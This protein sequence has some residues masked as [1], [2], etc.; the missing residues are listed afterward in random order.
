MVV[1]DHAFLGVEDGAVVDDQSVDE[2]QPHTNLQMP[3][4]HQPGQELGA[5]GCSPLVAR[6]YALEGE[7]VYEVIAENGFGWGSRRQGV[8]V[9]LAKEYACDQAHL[10][11][12]Q[13]IR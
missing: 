9:G 8:D 11:V 10:P 5:E 4:S 12:A 3:T 1:F 7:V 6:L 13:A 2:G